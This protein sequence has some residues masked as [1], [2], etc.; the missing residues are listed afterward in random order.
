MRRFFIEPDQ[1]NSATA[2]IEGTD[3]RHIRT[4]LRS[5]P[6]DEIF[7]F[8]GRGTDYRSRILEVTTRGIYLQV[9]DQFPSTAESPVHITVGQ[10][11]IRTQKMDRFIRQ[12]TELGG[13]AFLAFWA[14]RSTVKPDQ[15]RSQKKQRRW[16]KI[17]AESLKQ[18]GRSRVPD[19]RPIQ[20][21]QDVLSS[22]CDYD[23]R[24]IFHNTGD[25]RS[26]TDLKE[27]RGTARR[28]LALVGPEGGF[29]SGEVE[30]ADQHGFTVC[31][32]GPRLLKSDTAGIAALTLIQHRFG[33]LGNSKRA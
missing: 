14:K 21:F 17:A 26:L 20:S 7:L 3:A 1:L 31:H 4:V 27:N 25:A 23:L 6:G 10:A 11:L 15:D 2:F 19:I 18:C 22:C 13:N 5:K 16:E 12:F 30:L 29:T 9:L 28:I 8:D 24:L 32:M 33:D